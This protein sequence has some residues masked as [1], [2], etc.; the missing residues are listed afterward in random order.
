[1]YLGNLPIIGHLG[2]D[3]E[4]R[5][6]PSGRAVANFSVAVNRQYTGGKGET[7]KETYWFRCTAWDKQAEICN[8]YLKKGSKVFIEGRLSADPA[9]GGPRIWTKQDGTPQASFELTIFTIKFLDGK[10]DSVPEGGSG[11]GNS[12]SLEAPDDDIPF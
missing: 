12:G 6:T 2:R 5:F 4:M 9:S 7:V 1:M 8:Q 10:S 11:G 3:V